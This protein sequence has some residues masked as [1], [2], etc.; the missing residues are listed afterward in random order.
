MS[1]IYDFVNYNRS[2][3]QLAKE[4]NFTFNLYRGRVDWKKLE[5]VEIDRI[6]RDQDV[7]LLN[8]YMDSVTNCNLDSEYDV[9]ILDP[10]F[11]KLFRLAQ[12]LIDF[13]IHC[14]KYL[15][16]CIKVAHESL[17]ASNKEV[18]LL[19]K[20]LQARKSEV[21]Q[22]KKKVKEVKQQLLHSPRVSNPTFQCSLC[23]KLF[24]NE[25][26]LHGHYS[27]RHQS[28][29]C[30]GLKPQPTPQPS[31]I[32]IDKRE[33]EEYTNKPEDMTNI[34]KKYQ[35]EIEELKNMFFAEIEVTFSCR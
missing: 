30:L 22:L 24:M 13:L 21:K 29:Y 15:E 14:K 26:Y 28:S 4:S 20:Q 25:S 19:R 32:K 3:S 10:N 8:I 9:K 35:E 33:N 6:V 16:H 7:E 12:L 27:R 11:I 2:F 5:V 18:E 23:G 34:K 1:V 17:Q 31:P